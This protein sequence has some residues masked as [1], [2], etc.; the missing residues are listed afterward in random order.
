MR[1]VNVARNLFPNP[2]QVPQ[3]QFFSSPNSQPHG[4]YS[5]ADVEYVPDSQ[6]E[7]MSVPTAR[8]RKGKEVATGSA[9]GRNV[10]WTE[11]EDLVL[12]RCY[13][14]VCSDPRVGTNQRYD[15]LFKNIHERFENAKRYGLYPGLTSRTTDSLRKRVERIKAEMNHWMGCYET[16]TKNVGQRSGCNEEDVLSMAQELHKENSK[17]H[18]GFAMFKQWQLM[19][20]YPQ[21]EM[22]LNWETTLKKKELQPIDLD[23]VGSAQKES[24][25]GSSGTK[26]FR[27]VDRSEERRVGKECRL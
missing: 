21:Y 1:P 26:R 2:L 22:Y 11:N 8:S 16:A 17:Y 6:P 5:Q 12:L 18:C 23:D 10:Q 20:D 27:L 24:T 9:Q 25:G 15:T 14:D 3:S 19:K 7:S 13:F 4:M